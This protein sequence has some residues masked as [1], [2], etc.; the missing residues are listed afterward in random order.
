MMRTLKSGGRSGMIGHNRKRSPDRDDA[1]LA[2]SDEE[3][4]EMVAAA[5]A[6]GSWHHGW[7]PRLLRLAK[8]GAEAARLPGITPAGMFDERFTWSRS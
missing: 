1:M 4:I 8:R 6:A 5:T 2:A 7:L 3:F